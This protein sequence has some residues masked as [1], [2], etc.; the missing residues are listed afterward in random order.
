LTERIS[1]QSF[2]IV[3]DAEKLAYAFNQL[4]AAAA[5]LSDYGSTITAE[6]SHGREQEVM[7]KI[8]ISGSGLTPEAL[9]RVFDRSINSSVPAAAQDTDAMH[10]SLNAVHDIVGMH[11]GRMF[12]N[13]T[14]GQGSTLLFTL[15][16]VTIGGEDKNNEQ[17]VNISR[18]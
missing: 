3:A 8:S 11:G 2:E 15:P 7:V 5:K 4:I 9:N 1:D 6:F 12:V 17:A 16:A 10:M 14:P 18:R 13:S